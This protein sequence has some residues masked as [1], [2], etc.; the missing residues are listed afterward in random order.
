MNFLAHSY[1]SFNDPQTIVGNYLGDFHKGSKQGDIPTE[2]FKGIMLHRKIDTYTDQ[3][4]YH[5]EARKFLYPH[6][7]KGSGIAVDIFFDHYLAKNWSQWHEQDL[8]E[9]SSWVYSTLQE[10]CHLFNPKAQWVFENMSTWNWL[11]SYKEHS[12][13]KRAF[14]GMHQ[15]T[16]QKFGFDK[17][18][19]LLL[20]HY[21]EFEQCFNNILPDLRTFTNRERLLL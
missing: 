15:R 3:H 17:A 1:L 11:K 4:P 2:V 19:D 16:E 18:P 21:S 14:E 13:I 12:G 8:D 7:G 9:F 5:E 10:Y 6:L 20:K